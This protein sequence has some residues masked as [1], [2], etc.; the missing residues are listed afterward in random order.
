MRKL[1]HFSLGRLV[2]VVHEK[3]FLMYAVF[4]DVNEKV[5]RSIKYTSSMIPGW[6]LGNGTI[7]EHVKSICRSVSRRPSILL[8]E[9][10]IIVTL[11]LGIEI[12]LAREKAVKRLGTIAE[13]DECHVCNQAKNIRPTCSSR[14][15]T[16]ECQ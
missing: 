15:V 11:T 3:P 5:W 1:Y 12:H 10:S 13:I 2:I 14:M 4:K 6:H 9:M 8:E 16:R 7:S